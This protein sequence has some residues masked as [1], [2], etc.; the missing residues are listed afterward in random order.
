MGGVSIG[1]Y[2]YLERL[3]V[4]VR[5]YRVP[6]RSLP[7][8]FEGFT[9]LHLTDLHD[10]EFGRSGED[11]I[12]LVSSERFDLVALTGDMVVGVRPQ[13]TPTLELVAGINRIS[14]APVYSVAG[15]HEWRLDRGAEFNAR[16][17]EA[18]VRVLSNGSAALERGKDR[19]WIV[20]VDDPVTRRDR[21][22]QALEGTD[23]NSPRLLLAHS[24]HPY[25]L[26]VKNGLDLVLAGHT[27]GGQVRIPLLGASYVPAMGFF[28]RW[29]YGIYSC[30]PTTMIVSGGL[31]ES[32]LPV[33]FNV[34]PE[35]SLITL[36]RLQATRRTEDATG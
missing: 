9:I 11:L 36:Q 17:G 26:A 34:R 13:F 6:V 16:L 28:P 1:P 22:D 29:D 23:A 32:G 3:S 27:H 2:L 15:N 5:R 14:R 18:G 30:G 24:P 33:R 19:L 21:L 25:P 8:A 4:A 7:A 31:G 35:V 20:G 12:N 10:K